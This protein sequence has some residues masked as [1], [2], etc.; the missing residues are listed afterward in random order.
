MHAK[1][2]LPCEGL[3]LGL[4]FLLAFGVLGG[5]YAGVGAEHF[6]KMVDTVIA[7][8]FGHLADGFII[9]EQNGLGL[10]DPKIMKVFDG[11]KAVNTLESLAKIHRADA[12]QPSQTV[13]G[14]GAVVVA[15]GDI[16]H[17]RA[18]HFLLILGGIF[19]IGCA[20]EGKQDAIQQVG[21]L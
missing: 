15:G 20:S 10:I 16:V 18:Q 13:V 6:G 14:N 3:P 9:A 21:R 2:L 8:A 11:R 19:F 1:P 17:G 12:A 5:A 4:A 7:H